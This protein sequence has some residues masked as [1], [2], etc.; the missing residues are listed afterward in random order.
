MH[1]HAKLWVVFFFLIN[2]CWKEKKQTTLWFL[3]CWGHSM[4]MFCSSQTA[5]QTFQNLMILLGLWLILG[6]HREKPNERTFDILFK[7]SVAIS[8]D[9]FIHLYGRWTLINTPVLYKNVSELD[10][11]LNVR[12]DYRNT[13]TLKNKVAFVNKVGKGWINSQ[14][15]FRVNTTNKW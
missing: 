1:S 6:Y 11:L 7:P 12:H 15:F 2:R 13:I 14:Q 5:L 8:L 9:L 3:F 4:N 10:L